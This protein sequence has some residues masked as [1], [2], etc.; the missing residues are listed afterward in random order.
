MR[1]ISAPTQPKTAAS[2]P[3]AWPFLAVG[4]LILLALWLLWPTPPVQ[5]EISSLPARVQSQALVPLDGIVQV[6]AGGYHTCALTTAG[7]VKCWGSNENG[8]LGDGTTVDKSTPVGVVGLGSGVAAIATGGDYTCAL[9]TAGGAKCWGRNDRGQLGNGT[10]SYETTPVDVVG[11]DSGVAAIAAGFTHTCAL[12]TVGGVKCWGY[13]FFGQLGDGMRADKSPAVDVVGLASGVMAIATGGGHTCAL[14][15]AGGVK[16]WGKNYEG[17]LGDGTTGNFKTTP[18]DVTGLGSDVTAIATGGDYTCALITRGKVKCWGYDSLGQLMISPTPGDV[19]GLDSNVDVTTGS[20]HICALTTAGGVKCWGANIFG[21]LGNGTEAR[22]ASP[23]DVVGLGSGVVAIAAGGMHTCALTTSGGVKCWGYN[24]SGELGVGIEANKPTPVDVVGLASGMA[25]MDTGGY[26]TCALSTTSRV[27]CWGNNENGQ[28]GN[29]TQ[30]SKNTPTDVGGLGS[31]VA[32]IAT[33]GGHTCALTTGGGVKCWGNNSAGQL[34]NGIFGGSNWYS[35]NSTPVDVVGLVG[36]VAAIAAG[37]YHTCALT[38]AGGAKCWGSSYHG[39]LGDGTA[40]WISSTPVDVVGLGSGVAAITAGDTHTCA[41]TTAGGVK[42]WGNNDRGQLGDGTALSRLTPVDVIGLESGVVAIDT[43][44]QHTCALTTAGGVKC[45]GDGGQLGDGTT[46]DKSIPVD[47]VGLGSGVVAI[48]TGGFHTCALTTAGG[49]KC[50]GGNG[51]GQLGDG[52]L[53]NKSTPVDV[54][55]LG[56]GVIA[57]AAS[58]FEFAYHT[59]ALTTAG[60]VKCWGSND[61]GQL[62][63]DTA[64]RSAPVDVLVEGTGAPTLPPL[65]VVHGI[66]LFG[67]GYQCTDAPGLYPIVSTTLGDLPGWFTQDYQVWI[68]HLDSKPIRTPSIATNAECLKK[69]V[70][71][72][73]EASGHQS[74]TII[75]HSMGGL[76]SRACLSEP[77]CQDKVKALYTLGSPHGGQNLDMILKALIASGFSSRTE[78]GICLVQPALCQL[79]TDNMVLFNAEHPNQSGID[80]TFIGGDATPLFPGWLIW[81]TE[82]RNDGIVGSL[83][84]VGWASN[85]GIY[86]PLTWP[87]ASMPVQ[88]WTDEV[89]IGDWGNAYYENRPDTADGRSQSYACIQHQMGKI[90]QSDFC[91]DPLAARQARSATEAPTLSQTTTS[92]DGVLSTGQTVTHTLSVDTAAAS[93]FTLAW[94]DGTVAFTLLRP[95]G[96]A[97]TPAYAAA[98]PEEVV[99]TSAIGSPE[100]PAFAS[101]AFTN[102][103]PGDWQLQIEGT[104]VGDAGAGYVGFVAMETARSLTVSQDRTLYAVGDTATFTATLQGGSGGITGATVTAALNRPDGITETLTLA[105]VG[106]GVYRTDYLVPD[107][108]GRV[109]MSVVATGSDGGVPF[110]RQEERIWTIAPDTAQFTGVTTDRGIDENGNGRFESL[111]VNVQV[112]VTQPATYTLSARLSKGGVS[113]ASTAV[114]SEIAAAGVYTLPL[115]FDGSDIWAAQ[116]DGPY[117][118]TDAV[119]NNIS[120]GSV[121]VANAETL[122]TTT[123]YAAADFAPDMPPLALTIDGPTAGF[124]GSSYLFTATT[125]TITATLPLTYTW[126]ASGQNQIV[127]SASWTDTVTYTWNAIGEQTIEVAASNSAGVVTTT[128]TITIGEAP[129]STPTPTETPTETPTSTPTET[130]TSTPTATSTPSPTSTSTATPTSTITPTSTPSSTNTPTATGTPTPTPSP[131]PTASATPTGT[132]IPTAT[133]T[134]TPTGTPSPTPTASVTPTGTLTPTRTPTATPTGTPTGTPSPTPTASVTPTGTLTPTRTPIASAT[135]T[136]TSNRT[137]HQVFLPALRR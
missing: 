123:A 64:W 44:H 10:Q 21:Q 67:E 91:R 133:P 46:A 109:V 15:M 125:D 108:G 95:D 81:R 124:V 96:Q 98:H 94:S 117:S 107:A 74:I 83:S 66:Q 88:Y 59:C 79:A 52:T 130:H 115:S 131:T 30:E 77:D 73:Y 29:S 118:V 11:L 12:T 128:H 85:I 25:A 28:L 8:Q 61:Y 51:Y 127:R 65:L 35:G 97:V 5:A 100:F 86:W 136:P 114:Y 92:I 62:G 129:T 71:A 112:N 49:V 23:V 68:A 99:F 121:P 56:S 19:I 54:V 40:G 18:M 78:K 6:A 116:Q 57:I 14:T 3:T 27:K 45:W 1:Q 37:S 31:N 43:G 50:W 104:D 9:T 102:T 110:T 105:D 48:S 76:V 84:A 17:Q 20:H 38:T 132:R 72:L 119:L 41:L 63:D 101:Y 122:H 60:G 75:A 137:N 24:F 22:E 42:C 39:R 13:N 33:G 53:G 135:P 90:A 106:G 58:G 89:H 111:W 87:T 47:V 126:Q 7:G 34:G 134:G 32:A 70:S 2:L 113:I 103:L 55:G 16:C 26:H 82:G 69:Q 93:L 36:G 80:Y 120:I 4:A